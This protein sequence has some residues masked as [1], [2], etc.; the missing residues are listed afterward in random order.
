MNIRKKK[1]KYGVCQYCG[2]YVRENR[3]ICAACYTK[4]KLLPRFKVATDNI[5]K[6][7]GYGTENNDTNRV[8]V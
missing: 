7:I 4:L 1:T 8:R 6:E 5:K 2:S 3:A